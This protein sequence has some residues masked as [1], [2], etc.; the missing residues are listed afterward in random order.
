MLPTVCYTPGVWDLLHAGHLNLI[1][2]AKLAGDYLIIGVCSDRLV[3]QTK[4]EPIVN[5]DDRAKLLVSL[6]GVDEVY[7]YDALDQTA[8]LQFLGVNVFCVGPEFGDLP[9][10]QRALAYCRENSIQIR[11]VPRYPGVSSTEIRQRAVERQRLQ[12]GKAIAVDFHDCITFD[13]VFFERLFS[14]WPGKRYILSGTP[15]CE[16]QKVLGELA[17]LGFEEGRNFENLLLGY[18]YDRDKMDLD[19]F[20]RMREHKL[21]HIKKHNIKVFIDDNPFYV[22]WMK[23]H[24]VT[25]FQMILP[26]SYTQAFGRKD[27]YFSCHLQEKQF[28][29]LRVMRDEDVC[30]HDTDLPS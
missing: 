30:A 19:H 14:F 23:E 7:I 10:H 26:S 5:Q 16:R 28:E 3:R 24:G 18:N 27:P 9:E 12:D 2:R 22:D 25:T 6:E 4:A 13:A 29:F 20:K 8:A 17:L 1:K 21:Q 15:E 11:T